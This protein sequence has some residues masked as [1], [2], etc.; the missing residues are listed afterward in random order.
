MHFLDSEWNDLLVG[1]SA[2]LHMAQIC[3]EQRDRKDRLWDSF[4]SLLSRPASRDEDGPRFSLTNALQSICIEF[5]ST[6]P[7]NDVVRWQR[8]TDIALNMHIHEFY[9]VAQFK[10]TSVL[11]KGL[12]RIHEWLVVSNQY[13]QC[14]LYLSQPHGLIQLDWGYVSMYDHMHEAVGGSSR[15]LS[16]FCRMFSISWRCWA[17]KITIW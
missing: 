10:C 7:W 14:I 13:W 5:S 2:L 11:D 15:A 16:L 17:Y 9:I 8:T 6:H 3:R 4:L 1:S 12:H